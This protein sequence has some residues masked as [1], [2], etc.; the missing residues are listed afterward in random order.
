[1]NTKMYVGNLPWTA[2]EDDVRSLFASHGEVREVN[3]PTDRTS[4]R[5]RGF[6]FV[7]MDSAEAMQTAIRTLNGKDWMQR[8]LEVTEARPR[9]ER[10]AGQMNGNSGGS[11]RW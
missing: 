4:G 7:T 8:K 1:M 2:S 10:P 5:P 6:A 3:L 9:E 11:G